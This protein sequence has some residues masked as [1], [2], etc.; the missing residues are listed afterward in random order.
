MCMNF[1]SKELKIVF[2][3][4]AWWGGGGGQGWQKLRPLQGVPAPSQEL[5][6]TGL[7]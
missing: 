6:F 4:R 7:I 5:S 1:L 2:Y 3:F